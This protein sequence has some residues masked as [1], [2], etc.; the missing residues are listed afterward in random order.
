MQ[1][2]IT[3]SSTYEIILNFAISLRIKNTSISCY[4]TS[5]TDFSVNNTVLQVYAM[6]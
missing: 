3:D 5:F 4:I 1:K 2:I 6:H